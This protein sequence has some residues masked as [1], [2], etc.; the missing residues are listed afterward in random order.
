[1]IHKGWC[2]PAPLLTFVTVANIDVSRTGITE[3][4]TV[5]RTV[6][7]QLLCID[8]A[9]GISLLSTDTDLQPTGN[10]LTHIDNAPF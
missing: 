5:E 4:F 2:P 8:N 3:V 9:D 6:S 7:I 10:V 1:M